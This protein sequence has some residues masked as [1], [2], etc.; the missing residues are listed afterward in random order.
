[1]AVVEALRA[2]GYRVRA[3]GRDMARGA[4][5]ETLGA[6]FIAADL[7]APGVGQVLVAGMDSVIHT[8]ALSSPWGAKAA[9]RA[10]NVEATEALLQA[11]KSEKCQRFVFVSSP[12]VYAR[13]VDQP[14]LKESDPVTQ[15]PLNAYAATKIEAERRVAVFAGPDMA[16]VSIRPRAIIGPDDTVLLP[17]VIRLLRKGRFPLLRGGKVLIE[18]TDVRDVAQALVLA[19]QRAPLLNGE[20]V[21]ISGGKALP[22]RNMIERF[23]KALNL[24]V[25]FVPVPYGPLS[26]AVAGMEAM[27]RILPGQPE[28]PLTVYG[29]TTLAFSQTFDLS[30]ARERL[31]YKPCYD[32]FQSAIEAAS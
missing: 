15:R 4:R 22:V 8:A 26:V 17:R 32:A 23:S 30:L 16:C 31:G 9:F 6:E 5:L 12:S 2:Q 13:A 10:I 24:P 29:L 14:D 7:C 3:T 25:R 21:N 11:A 27:C 18:L 20:V 28:P 1:M 19:E